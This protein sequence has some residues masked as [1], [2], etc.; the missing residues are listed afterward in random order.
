VG[1]SLVESLLGLP[2]HDQCE[3]YHLLGSSLGFEEDEPDKQD[4]RR[5]EL[6]ERAEALEAMR[7]AA[8]RLGLP[9]GKRLAVRDYERARRELGLGISS[10]AIIRR[11]GSWREAV[12]VMGGEPARTTQRQ[13]A[14]W[15]EIN[16]SARAREQH[17][18]GVREWLEGKPATISKRAYDDFA[19]SPDRQGTGA[20]PL[21]TADA[22]TDA[23]VLPWRT[24]LAVARGEKALGAAQRER[25]TEL[26]REGG[27]LG[28]VSVA[29][30]A[31][32]HGGSEK[33]AYKLVRAEGFPVPAAYTTMNG[34][35]AWYRHDV[36]AHHAGRRVPKRRLFEAQGK[37]ILSE[38]VRAL[39]GPPASEFE[40]MVARSQLASRCEAQDG[41]LLPRPDGRVNHAFYWLRADI[42]AWND[43]RGPEGQGKG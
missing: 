12:S 16:N 13:R 40:R 32:L 17:L 42:E 26:R 34:R 30:I 22:V 39:L 15:L 35:R 1:A 27:S 25:K 2:W 28:L 18:A 10:A 20:L 24:T 8:E 5:K 7:G 37:I 38:E 19:L 14:R 31:L 33:A 43:R 21:V 4:E 3:V 29:Y 6:S 23:L 41:N 9:D 36:E 11:W